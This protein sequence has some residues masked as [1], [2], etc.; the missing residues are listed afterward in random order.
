MRLFQVVPVPGIFTRGR[1][2][3]RDYREDD[4]PDSRDQILDFTD[5]REREGK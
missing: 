5:I 2:K 1:W 3:C 4:H